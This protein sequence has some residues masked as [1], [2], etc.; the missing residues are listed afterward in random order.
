MIH[1]ELKLRRSFVRNFELLFGC[2]LS[3]YILI[4]IWYRSFLA[5]LCERLLDYDENVRKQV[6]AV[7]CDV[8]CRALSSIEVERIKLVADRLRDKSVC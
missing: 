4:L 3:F 2:V 7:L 6:V 8:A 5:A 1:L